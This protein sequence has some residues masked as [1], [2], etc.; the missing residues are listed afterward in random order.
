MALIVGSSLVI[1]LRE[2]IENL[3]SPI[4]QKII[5]KFSILSVND[6]P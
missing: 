2:K 4:F 1:P 5:H 3:D 6:F